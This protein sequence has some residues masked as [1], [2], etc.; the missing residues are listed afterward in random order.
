MNQVLHL[1][2]LYLADD[3]KDIIKFSQTC[4]AAHDFCQ[5]PALWQDVF[6]ETC[7]GAGPKLQDSRDVVLRRAKVQ[8]TTRGL[9]D[10][11]LET[12][13][14][15]VEVLRDR[16]P[17]DVPRQDDDEEDGEVLSFM[18]AEDIWEPRSANELWIDKLDTRGLAFVVSPHEESEIPQHVQRAIAHLQTLSELAS[19]VRE[20]SL[21][22]AH[23]AAASRAV[24][25][26]IDKIDDNALQSAREVVYERSN[27][28]RA[29]GWGPFLEGDRAG[30][31]NWK[32]LSA[33]SIVM[34]KSF[35]Q[36]GD[37]WSD[38]GTS[39]PRGVLSTCPGPVRREH[40]NPRDWAGVE[41]WEWRGTYQFLDF[42]SYTHYVFHRRRNMIPSLE[43]EEDQ[44]GNC[45][46]LE[47]TL[48]PPGKVSCGRFVA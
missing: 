35:E 34:A 4:K 18:A 45:L 43:G 30:E 2:L 11:P 47:F 37:E 32:A 46:T 31:T 26:N 19:S 20:G 25:P 5:S 36:N 17:W 22:D 15:I 12:Y 41:D 10:A 6:F 44:L 16:V 8:A 42:T 13:E 21:D 7:D 3:V 33:I 27:C 1:C 48:L 9:S 40:L 39:I 14:T 23:R 24:T 38:Y 29:N 28:S